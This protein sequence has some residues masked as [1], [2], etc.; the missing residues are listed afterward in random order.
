MSA[1]ARRAFH[2]GL[3]GCAA[4]LL[5]PLL[6]CPAPELAPLD[7]QELSADPMGKWGDELQALD[8]VRE[9]LKEWWPEKAVDE[10]WLENEALCRLHW[11]RRALLNKCDGKVHM[12]HRQYPL[13]PE[14]ALSSG[15]KSVFD[16]RRLTYRRSVL[17]KDEREHGYYPTFD[18]DPSSTTSFKFKERDGGPLTLFHRPV[19]GQAYVLG[20]DLGGGN[21]DGDPSVIQVL[22][23]GQGTEA[24]FLYQAARYEGW[25]S[26]NAFTELVWDLADYYEDG[27]VVPEST[28]IGATFIEKSKDLGRQR[29]FLRKSRVDDVFEK[30]IDKW[31]FHTSGLTKP[32]LIHTTQDAIERDRIEFNDPPT[33]KQLLAYAH[34]PDTNRYSAPKGQHDD[35][36]IALCLAVIGADFARPKSAIKR[37]ILTEFERF[38]LGL[39]PKE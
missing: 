29:M 1:I 6:A 2:A 18:Y 9:G 39:K 8:Y 23:V 7:L 3:S 37:R 17:E 33:I 11:R 36:V 14:E 30:T 35:M 28:G 4:L 21:E 5:A 38:K 19:P 10:D 24:G 20:V 26:P 13:T 15:G 12:L 34:D 31:G 27:F 32:T 25:I 22:R 16:V